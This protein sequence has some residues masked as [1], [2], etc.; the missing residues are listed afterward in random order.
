[1]WQTKSKTAGKMLSGKLSVEKVVFQCFVLLLGYFPFIFPS[2]S[3]LLENYH[4][5][6]L[7][8]VISTPHYT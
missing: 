4:F 8:R 3:S 7:E 2:F 6:E 5:N 1:M